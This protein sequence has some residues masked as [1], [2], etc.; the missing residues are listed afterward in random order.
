MKTYKAKLVG[1][2]TMEYGSKEKSIEIQAEDKDSAKEKA[3]KYCKE[4][5]FMG[6]YD[7]YVSRVE[8]VEQDDR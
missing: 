4:H 2:D 6:G 7:W 1:Y 8:E 3:D 5:S